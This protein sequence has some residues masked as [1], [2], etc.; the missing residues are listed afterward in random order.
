MGRFLWKDRVVLIQHPTNH[1]CS[2]PSVWPKC[3]WCEAISA[4]RYESK[5]IAS[6]HLSYSAAQR[7]LTVDLAHVPVWVYACSVLYTPRSF[8]DPGEVI[9]WLSRTSMPRH[10]RQRRHGRTITAACALLDWQTNHHS[11]ELWQ[12][13]LRYKG[14]V[15]VK[16]HKLTRVHILLTSCWFFLRG[17]LGCRLADGNKEETSRPKCK[18]NLQASQR[19]W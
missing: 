7:H 13:W 8:A 12:P 16:P 2:R 9:R 6:P 4:S 17:L 1:C 10:S 3:C 19:K 11:L 18:W 14:G 5:P 15:V